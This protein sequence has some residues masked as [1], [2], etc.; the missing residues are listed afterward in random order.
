MA[1]SAGLLIQYM[2][3]D[4]SRVRIPFSP[5]CLSR[6]TVADATSPSPAFPKEPGFFVGFGLLSRFIPGTDCNVRSDSSACR[7]D[8]CAESMMVVGNKHVILFDCSDV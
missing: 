5:L 2:S 4:V 1:E 6:H 7:A 8:L 3:K